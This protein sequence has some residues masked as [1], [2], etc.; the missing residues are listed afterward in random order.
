MTSSASLEGVE[1]LFP[2][3]LC[4]TLWMTI[5]REQ[6]KLSCIRLRHFV[7][8]KQ[9]CEFVPERGFSLSDLIPNMDLEACVAFVADVTP[10]DEVGI[11]FR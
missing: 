5:G 4:H 9:V 8:F 6:G 3:Q 2:H 11:F 7:R 1:S 10:S